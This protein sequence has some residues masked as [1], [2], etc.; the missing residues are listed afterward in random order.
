MDARG[1]VVVM[2]AV[3][4]GSSAFS[5]YLEPPLHKPDWWKVPGDPA[6]GMTRT[7][8]RSF[9]T[10]PNPPDD[11]GDYTYNGFT[12]S[13]SDSW[14]DNLNLGY[15]VSWGPDCPEYGDRYCLNTEPPIALNVT[16]GNRSVQNGVKY[17]FIQTVGRSLGAG[18]HE[19]ELI[20][21][22]DGGADPWWDPDHVHTTDWIDCDN[23]GLGDIGVSTWSGKLLVEQPDWETFAFWVASDLVDSM[24]IG[25]HCIPE[26]AT[27]TLAAAAAAGLLGY[28]RRRRMR[29]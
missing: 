26:P 8:Y 5:D 17:Y 22:E 2:V 25:T 1:L 21:T 9:I 24:W 4:F 10:D 3:L 20:R 15:F 14:T 12:P 29:R 28:V 16:L 19:L 6:D 27:L 11:N 18:D 23:D 7:M 13:I